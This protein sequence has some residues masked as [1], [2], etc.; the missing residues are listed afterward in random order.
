[1]ANETTTVSA[2]R[3]EAVMRQNTVALRALPLLYPATSRLAW[4]DAAGLLQRRHR[5][6]LLFYSPTSQAHLRGALFEP[7]VDYRSVF[8]A[9]WIDC[10]LSLTMSGTVPFVIVDAML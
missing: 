10:S 4:R 1:M 5:V 7:I 8:T 6:A 9:G 2:E 3:Y